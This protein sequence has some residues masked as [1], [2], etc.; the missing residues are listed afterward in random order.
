MISG[1][2]G[3]LVLRPVPGRDTRPTLDRVRESVFAILTPRIAEAKVLDLFAG[4]GALGIEALS[5]G[6][7]SCVF[8]ESQSQALSVLRDNLQHTRL[9]ERASV[10]R[11]KLPQGLA[12]LQSFA[13][14]DIVLADPP[15]AFEQWPTLLDRLRAFLGPSAIVVCEHAR[16]ATI[17]PG[18]DLQLVRRAA[19][20]QTHVS[21][22]GRGGG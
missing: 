8:V 2:A 14:F 7:E 4:T 3:G 18:A 15:Y 11:L 5:R 9:S 12:H 19:Y 10:L 13:P 22:F 17:E 16:D 21:F 20:G 1:I 6:A